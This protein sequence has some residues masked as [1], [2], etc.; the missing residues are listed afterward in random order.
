MK[1]HIILS[2]LV[3]ALI[4]AA[5]DLQAQNKGK[6]GSKKGKDKKPAVQEP[7]LTQLPSNSNDCLFAIELQPDIVYGPTTAPQGAGRIQ[8]II[9]DKNNTHIFECEHN[10]TWYKFTVPYDGNLEIEI[11]T[12]NEWDDYD[13]ILYRYSDVYFSNHLLQNKIKPVAS[14]LATID[15]TGYGATLVKTAKG[16]VKSQNHHIATKPVMGMKV[17]GTHRFLGP[18][19]M[20]EFLASIPVKKGEIYYIVLDN[21]TNNGEG[22]SIMASIQVDSYEPMVTFYDNP[23]TKKPIVVDL[24]IL[25]KNTGNRAVVKN[26]SFKGGKIKFIPGF[27]Y[28]LYVK[29][30]GYFPRS[31]E[32]KSDIF[33]DDN[34]LEMRMVK[35]EK[36]SVFHIVDI[37]FND[38][39]ELL[40]E[41]DSTLMYYVQMFRNQPEMTFQ[42]KGFVTTY[43]V[44]IEADQQLSI[45]RAKS[46]KDFFVA[47]GVPEKNITIAGMTVNEI[48]RAAAAALNKHQAF[49]DTKV[50]ITILGI[51]Q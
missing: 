11:A 16:Q 37:Y 3:L 36:G 51:G 35:A 18:S 27:S 19:D 45:A 42:I 9:R 28:S 8:E 10:S 24:V 23:N 13:F 6:S 33:K 49:R 22:H 48:K 31:L 32:F 15:T 20:E 7:E 40:P 39:A 14:S 46:V 25:E 12:N 26:S 2:I 5:T 4:G 47:H 30:D 50:D 21:K 17:S 34:K 43:A 41:S 38:D 29:K 44:D 1:R